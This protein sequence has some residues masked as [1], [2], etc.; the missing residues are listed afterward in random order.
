MS[1]PCTVDGDI[2]VEQVP[3][4]CGMQ[5]VAGCVWSHMVESLTLALHFMLV[6]ILL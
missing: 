6:S 5:D 4:Y 2:V 1:I 3:I